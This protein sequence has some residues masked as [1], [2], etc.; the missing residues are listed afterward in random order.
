MKIIDLTGKRFGKL[1]VI[2]RNQELH[3]NQKVFWK[4]RCDCG[5]TKNVVTSSLRK[6]GGTRSCGCNRVRRV[7]NIGDRFGKLVVIK[8]VQ[9]FSN[10]WE[11]RCDCGNHINTT[12]FE[13]IH[14]RRGCSI[15]CANSLVYGEA[16]FNSVYNDSKRSAK[17][18]GYTWDI[19]K[20]IFRKITSSNCF[21]CGNPP[22][23][24]TNRSDLN[25]DYIH[26]GID[27]VN[28]ANGYVINNC[29]ACCWNCNKA[30]QSFSPKQFKNWVISVY[31]HWASLN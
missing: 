4:C 22:S 8:K 6:N 25:G 18:R 2:E 12:G 28:N 14:I 30:K 16:A 27:R 1:V 17:R 13:L 19:P 21:Y 24:R 23:M 3:E 31:N 7:V 11:C 20:N 5:K 9:E 10:I 29:V 15:S 26:N